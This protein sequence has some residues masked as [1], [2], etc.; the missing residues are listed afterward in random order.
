MDLAKLLPKHK[1]RGNNSDNRMDIVNQDSITYFVATADKEVPV[2][3]G[4]RKWE[5]AFQ[6]YSAIYLKVHLIS[7]S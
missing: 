2:I 6:I 5:Q 3:N 4:I 1:H 7:T